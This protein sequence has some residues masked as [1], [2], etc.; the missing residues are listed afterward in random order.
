MELSKCLQTKDLRRLFKLQMYYP[1]RTCRREETPCNNWRFKPKEVNLL[2]MHLQLLRRIVET[3]MAWLH[4]LTTVFNSSVQ[5]TQEGPL[6]VAVDRTTLRQQAR[7]QKEVDW[8]SQECL[9]RALWA[10]RP[11]LSRKG[12]LFN[13]Q[14]HLSLSSGLGACQNQQTWEHSLSTSF[15][16]QT[17]GRP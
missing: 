2:R 8:R 9:T 13:R 10:S 14:S 6:P 1:L 15:R 11:G 17:K 3:C 16:R 7:L 5:L 12:D 4:P